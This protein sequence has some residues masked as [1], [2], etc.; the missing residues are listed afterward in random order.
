MRNLKRALSLALSTVMLLGMMVVGTGASYADVTSKHN[1]E[2]IDVMQAVGVM[3]GDDKG[4]FNPDQKVTRNEMAVVMANLLDLKVS[5]FNAAKTPFTDVP[6]WAAPYVAAC[7]ADGII[8]GYSA[9]YFGGSDTV[10]AAQAALMMM[11]ALGYFQVQSDFGDDWQLATVKQASKIELYDGIDA[12]A[13]AALTRNEVAQLALNALEATMVENDADSGSISIGDIV[14]TNGSKYVDRETTKYD[15]TQANGKYDSGK[16]EKTLQLCENLY[17]EDLV[18]LDS[19]K[20]DNY[21]RPSTIWKYEKDEVGTYAKEPDAVYTANVKSKDLYSDLGLSNS[22]SA[23][24]VTVYVDGN[25]Q[26]DITKQAITKTETAKYEQVRGGV[27]EV[28][29]T[30]DDTKAT[31]CYIYNYIGVITD[32]NAK[33]DGDEGIYVE[34]DGAEYFIKDATGYAEDDV[35]VATLGVKDGK[36][37][38]EIVGAPETVTGYASAISS[39]KDLTIGGTKYYMGGGFTNGDGDVVDGIAKADFKADKDTTYIVYLDELGN[40]LAVVEDED[41]STDDVVYVYSVEIGSVLDGS[42]VKYAATAKVVT[43]DGTI[44]EYQ[45]SDTYTTEAGAKDDA[46]YKAASALAGKFGSLNYNKSDDEYT[47]DAIST[48]DYSSV[49]ATVKTGLKLASDDTKAALESGKTANWYLRNDTVYLFV[50]LND[51]KDDIDN[52][53]VKT[54]GVDYTTTAG[55]FVADGKNVKYVVFT[56]DSYTAESDDVV[57]LDNE[58]FNG[59]TEDD[60]KTFDAYYLGDKTTTEITVASVDGVNAD[61]LADSTAL[62]GFYKYSEKSDGALKLTKIAG[63]YTA[64]VDSYVLDT[65]MVNVD[66]DILEF[67]Q[68]SAT[69]KDAVVVDLTD[70]DKSAENAYGRNITSVSALDKLLE[71]EVTAADG[72]KQVYEVTASI[73]VNEDN[74]VENIFITNISL[75]NK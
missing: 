51:D 44:E 14:I 73:F 47:I 68:D 49:N 66:G 64:D 54:G 8:A 43:A 62:N 21:G 70:A 50:E 74:E 9:T 61:K 45:V 60:Y 4:N 12:S 39:D 46:D 71:R 36:V 25:T 17:N 38:A 3:I 27:M 52:V 72:S 10:T 67:T 2:A 40:M 55:Y 22:I 35:V 24:N 11:K 57:Y 23:D 13:T 34:V 33:K 53:E 56:N 58:K 7:K 48:D 69:V 5:D 32:D 29:L 6:Q 30:N 31:I 18:K 37:E 75:V 65:K 26:N 59:L 15:Y 42:K 63:G 1:Q 41:N 16:S 28:Y 20:S 19:G